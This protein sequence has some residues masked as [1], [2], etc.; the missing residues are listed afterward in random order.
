MQ[1]TSPVLRGHEHEEIV[2]AK[3]QPEYLSLPV[4]PIGSAS[5]GILLTR[6]ELSWRERLR[7]L[8]VGEMYV[9][10]MTFGQRLQPICPMVFPPG[11]S[12]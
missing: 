5:D 3:N 10:V 6:W 7:A 9:Q 11:E 2:L 8:F 12:D 1:P 4:L